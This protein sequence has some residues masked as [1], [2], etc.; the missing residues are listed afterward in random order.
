MKHQ[1][2]IDQVFKEGKVVKSYPLKLIYIKADFDDGADFKMGCSVP[3][4]QFK[5]ATDRN[6]VKRLIREAYRLNK[7]LIF[8]NITT[9][10]AFM[11]LYIGDSMPLYEQIQAATVSLLEKFKQELES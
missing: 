7:P 6:R 11:I 4:R 3:K 9:Q 5:K 8:N 1:K 2:L 10:C